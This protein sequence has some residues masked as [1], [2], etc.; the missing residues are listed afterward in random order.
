MFNILSGVGEALG[1]AFDVV[2]EYGGKVIDYS[3]DF[4]RFATTE[5]GVLVIAMV[6]RGVDFAINSLSSVEVAVTGWITNTVNMLRGFDAKNWIRVDFPRVD[7]LYSEVYGM[8]P[9]EDCAKANP[10]DQPLCNVRNALR[11]LARGILT[12]LYFAGKALL[13]ALSQLAIYILNALAWLAA[14]VLEKVVQPVVVAVLS[15]VRNVLV[16]IKNVACK[17]LM[18]APIGVRTYKGVMKALNSGSSLPGIF[19]RSMRGV[20]EGIGFAIVVMGISGCATPT[21]PGHPSVGLGY[22]VS[23]YAVVDVS[24]SAVAYAVVKHVCA[25]DSVSVSDGSLF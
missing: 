15:G 2:K 22:T 18:I 24:D 1:R 10:L 20:V 5:K 9:D 3:K 13:W 19:S 11:T 12:A 7:Q 6:T 25:C 17:Y 23:P 4:A 8:L 16:F 21:L 14:E